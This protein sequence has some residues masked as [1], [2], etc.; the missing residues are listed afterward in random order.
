V[1]NESGVVARGTGKGAAVTGTGFNVTDDGT[2]RHGANRQ[3]VAHSKLGL[4]ATV[5]K[6][7]SVHSFS[8]D[9]Q[10]LI[11]AISVGIPELHLGERSTSAGVVNDVFHHSL[12]VTFALSKVKLAVL[13][14]SF[15]VED[16]GLEHAS[17]ALPLAPDNTTH[18]STID[19]ARG[20]REERAGFA[21]SPDKNRSASRY[22]ARVAGSEPRPAVSQP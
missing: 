6:L 22:L 10:L 7:S 13:G 8:G 18:Y 11:K 14:R 20:E 3:N 2:L 1:R 5:N 4:L 12:N 17:F 16:M 19:D 21:A 9:E 15:P